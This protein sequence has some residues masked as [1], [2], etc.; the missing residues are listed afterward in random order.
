MALHNKK[1]VTF[2]YVTLQ[3]RH[4]IKSYLMCM[5]CMSK[6][7]ILNDS[8]CLTKF[9][10]RLWR[11]VLEKERNWELVSNSSHQYRPRFIA[12]Q[13]LN[14]LLIIQQ[15]RLAHCEYSALHVT[16]FSHVGLPLATIFY[17]LLICQLFPRLICSLFSLYNVKKK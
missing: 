16:C 15:N 8:N 10:R 7:K 3:I 5:L 9:D 14:P 12:T 2:N 6:S 4:I 13:K 17:Y 11:S 1:W